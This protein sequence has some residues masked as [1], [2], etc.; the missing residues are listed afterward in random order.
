M[1]H[2]PLPKCRCGKVLCA[3]L[4]D[5]RRIHARIWAAKGGDQLVRFY[6]CGTGAYHWTREL[7]PNYHMKAA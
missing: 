2:P 1:K 7:D 3:D 6:R 5:A 4:D